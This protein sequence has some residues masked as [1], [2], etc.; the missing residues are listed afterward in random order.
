M[1]IVQRREE[2][3]CASRNYPLLH[4]YHFY[5]VKAVVGDRISGNRAIAAI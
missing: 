1:I 3:I 2:V 4:D 5:L